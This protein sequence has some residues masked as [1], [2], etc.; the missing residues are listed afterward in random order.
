MMDDLNPRLF[1]SYSWTSPE[2]EKWV[3]EL[4]TELRESGV[5]VIIDKWDLKEGHD[6]HIFMEKM[7]TDQS[8]K[9]VVIICDKVYAEKADGRSG[10][11]GTETQ[12]ISPEVYSK[13]EQNKFV[14]VVAERDDQGNAF[15]PVYYKS[16]IYI[17][18]SD[19][20]LYAKNFE[21]LLR[22]IYDKPLYIKPELGKMP[23]FLDD[24]ASITLGT[25][26]KAKRVVDAI[27]NNKDFCRGA[28]NE[29]FEVF[30]AN[31]ER[32]RI[33]EN[34][35]EFDDKVIESIEQ[36]IP[37]RNEAIE[38]FFSLAQYKDAPET[39]DQVHRFFEGL[40][41][42]MFKPDHISRYS[43][44]DFDNFRFIVHELFL[45][46][47]AS[48]LKYGRFDAVG[49]LLRHQFYFE[50]NEST[51]TV[52]FAII[53]QP[54]KS[55]KYR[56]ER[57]NLRRL[58]LRADLLTQRTKGS[59]FSE[60]QLMQ[61][62]FVLYIRDCIDAI[63]YGT[64][65]QWWPETLLYEEGR[66][67]AFEIFT[68]SQSLEYFNKLKRLFDIENKADMEPLLKA[69]QDKKLHIPTW[70]FDSFNPAALMGFQLLSTKP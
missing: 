49:H 36:F 38:V 57:L 15:L 51:K 30:T 31:L 61:T 59:G 47:V 18:L 66:E 27:R 4:A 52:S 35:G 10:G 33:M 62:D 17:D 1:V 20:A 41:A 29:Y 64:Y 48:Y 45:Y 69:F 43:E 16:R 67:G 53:R 7:V 26:F 54:M 6:A 58:S 8:I 68:R 50:R 65:Q 46:V 37:N 55:L 23:A 32:L 40:L 9:K 70:Q 13:E 21:Q 34:G 5:D 14:A 2:H 25:S 19:S 44:W 28:L 11:V 24:S 56:D 63:R 39:V 42:Y 60:R 22:W 12:I 3:L